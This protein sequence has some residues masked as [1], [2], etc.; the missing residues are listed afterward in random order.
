M[1]KFPFTQTSYQQN[2]YVVHELLKKCVRN[3]NKRFWLSQLRD[4]ISTSI[5]ISL[6]RLK[7]RKYANK[8][9]GKILLLSKTKFLDLIL[10]SLG[11]N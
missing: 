2:S 9:I 11:L 5:N 8:I 6:H 4:N 7:S 1:N 10:F 3:Q